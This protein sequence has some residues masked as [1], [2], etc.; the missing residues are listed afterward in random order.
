MPYRPLRPDQSWRPAAS[1]Y[2]A[3]FGTCRRRTT[4][5]WTLPADQTEGWPGVLRRPA[6]RPI[7]GEP[8]DYR[9]EFYY[10]DRVLRRPAAQT[11][12]GE[13]TE[14]CT[15][16]PPPRKGS[17]WWR[18][19]AGRGE[20]GVGCAAGPNRSG[21][22]HAPS[23]RFPVGFRNLTGRPAIKCHAD[24][25]LR[26]PAAGSIAGDPAGN[27]SGFLSDVQPMRNQTCALRYSAYDRSPADR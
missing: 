27:R 5:R 8:A 14:N 15:D 1:S 7:A 3:G 26:R 13:P 18:K 6:R 22:P 16:F 11:I 23:A 19:K 12:A 17:A 20:A 24:R 4:P 25:V 9:G 21:R 2:P 10:P